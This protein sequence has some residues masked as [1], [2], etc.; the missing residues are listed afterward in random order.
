M[1]S[2]V[3]TKSYNSPEVNKKEIFRYLGCGECDAKIDA[4]ADECIAEVMGLLSYRACYA[5]Y[6]IMLDGE[7]ID[8]GF[9][10]VNSHSLGICL[11]GCDEI[12]LFCATIG[13]S[14]DR[15]IEKYS[16]TSPSRAVMLQAIGSERVESLCD[17]LCREIAEAEKANGRV[18]R[19]RFSPGYGDLALEVQSEVFA[20][21]EPSVK[22]GVSLNENLFMRPTKSVSAIIGI[23]S[24]Q[25]LE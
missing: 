16:L 21:L 17:E 2:I 8:L 12:I 14:I 11:E 18:T 19:P 22:I 25:L 15:L 24:A 10:S 20:S 1:K 7:K 4:L 6:P 23:K 13:S 5:R 9:T 3:Y